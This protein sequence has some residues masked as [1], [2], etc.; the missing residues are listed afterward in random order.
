MSYVSV[1]DIM[2]YLRGHQ[3]S[4]IVYEIS[5]LRRFIL[6]LNIHK[7]FKIFI[8]VKI[9]LKFQYNYVFHLSF[10]EI[11]FVLASYKHRGP[12]GT[13]P[14]VVIIHHVNNING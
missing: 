2:A 12:S 11:K 7:Y 3:Q 8:I 14:V 10:I 6:Y 1:A 5:I 9:S 4:K 13:A